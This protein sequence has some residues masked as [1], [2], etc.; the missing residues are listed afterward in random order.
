[1][2]VCVCACVRACMYICVC[3]HAHVCVSACVCVPVCVR[4]CVC[5][6]CI[7]CNMLCCQGDIDALFSSEDPLLNDRGMYRYLSSEQLFVLLGCLEESH[8]FAKTFN[9]NTEQKLALRKAGKY[10]YSLNHILV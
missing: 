8:Q 7:N 1:M 9:C 5:K 6:Q 3:V 10:I 2:C 4:V